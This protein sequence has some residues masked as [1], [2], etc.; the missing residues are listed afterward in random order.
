MPGPRL[1][2]LGSRA[3]YVVEP[4]DPQEDQLRAGRRPHDGPWGVPPAS[5]WGQIEYG[6]ERPPET[7][8]TSPGDWPRFY[9]LLRDAVTAGGPAPVH[10]RDAVATHAMPHP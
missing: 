3:A 1:R 5:H 9:A 10:P 4:V 6:A 8:C 2:V 7:V